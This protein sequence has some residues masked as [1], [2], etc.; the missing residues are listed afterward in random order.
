MGVHILQKDIIDQLR[1]VDALRYSEM[2]PRHIESSHFKY[3][4]DQL[5]KDGIVEQRSRGV[6]GLSVKGKAFTD[7]ISDHRINPSAMPKLITYTLL[8]D[9]TSYYLYRKEKEPYRG[10]LNMIGGKMHFG[11]TPAEA[12]LRE[13][14]EKT[15]ETLPETTLYGVVDIRI[16]TGTQHLTHA[17]AYVFGAK[18]ETPIEGLV[19][20]AKADIHDR[21]DLAPD[22]L[23][24]IQFIQKDTS[25]FIE[26]LTIHL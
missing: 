20:V 4:L 3:H 5:I 1:R 17:T 9:A 14:H 26:N 25:P 10:L 16:Y 21:D 13:V 15:H 8:Q 22:L 18:T 2:Q 19:E 23:S 11:E 24:I 7:K 6:Y 12:S